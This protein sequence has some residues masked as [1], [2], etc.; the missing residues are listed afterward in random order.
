MNDSIK[1]ALSLEQRF[2]R[3]Q[4]SLYESKFQKL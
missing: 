3:I 1:E 4:L 2:I